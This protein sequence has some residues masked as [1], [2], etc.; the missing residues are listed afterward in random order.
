MHFLEQIL[1]Q[2]PEET[3]ALVKKLKTMIV[4]RNKMVSQYSK[5]WEDFARKNKNRKRRTKGESM[6]LEYSIPIEVYMA[7]HEYWDDIIKNKKF[8]KH[9]EWKVGDGKD[10]A[11]LNKGII[12][13]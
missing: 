12:I 3:K 10:K 4:N 13:K 6:S 9:P 5:K 1:K 8:D 7:D 11:N 2:K